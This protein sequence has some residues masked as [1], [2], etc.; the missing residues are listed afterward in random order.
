MF[1]SELRRRGKGLLGS[2]QP[3]TRIEAV[4][5]EPSIMNHSMPHQITTPTTQGA[6]SAVQSV[7]RNGQHSFMAGD[8]ITFEQV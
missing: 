7:Q 4:T 3:G 6:T 1:S 2:P 8:V 5:P